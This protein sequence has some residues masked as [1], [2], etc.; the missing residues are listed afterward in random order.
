[1][2]SLGVSV[3]WSCNFSDN[4]VMSDPCTNLLLIAVSLTSR[5]AVCLVS[6]YKRLT[7]ISM[8]LCMK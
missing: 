1:M 6:S 7:Y 3:G 4:S 2:A 5:K 8:F